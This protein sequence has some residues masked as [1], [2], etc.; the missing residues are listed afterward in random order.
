MTSVMMDMENFLSFVDVMDKM[1]TMKC[2]HLEN[3]YT[4]DMKLLITILLLKGQ[5]Q[6]FWKPYNIL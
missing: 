2:T 4:Y 6:C 1:L 3:F 5:I